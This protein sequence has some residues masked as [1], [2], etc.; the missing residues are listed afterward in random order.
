MSLE[1]T[2]VGDP[3]G[4][5]KLD[6]HRDVEERVLRDI[7]PS[8]TRD[9]SERPGQSIVEMALAARDTC[10]LRS[11]AAQRKG[12]T[13]QQRRALLFVADLLDLAVARHPD[14]A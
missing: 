8:G 4:T 10:L 1:E 5:G 13:D 14:Q 12:L 9:S 11:I 3:N 6:L 7:P 2:R